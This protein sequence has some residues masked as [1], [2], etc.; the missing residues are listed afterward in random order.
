MIEQ[1]HGPQVPACSFPEE[2]GVAVG[3]AE[4]EVIKTRVDEGQ[5]ILYRFPGPF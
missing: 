5:G 3:H 1:N 2:K 4:R